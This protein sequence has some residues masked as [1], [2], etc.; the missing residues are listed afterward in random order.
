MQKIV[1]S[2]SY[3]FEGVLP[4]EV[5]A[6][7]EKWGRVVKR[8]EIY[9]YTLDSGEIKA[10]KVSESPSELVRRIYVHPGCGCVLEL[11]ERRNFETGEVTYSVY[12][13][14]L[15]PSHQT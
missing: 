3:V 5:V 13:Q 9:A 6:L 2:K 15:C 14:R 1:R 8:G 10:K 11:D 12:R 4:D 7:L